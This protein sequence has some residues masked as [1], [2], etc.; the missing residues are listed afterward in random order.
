MVGVK[1]MSH[2]QDLERSVLFPDA[3]E[4]RIVLRRSSKLFHCFILVLQGEKKK[5]IVQSTYWLNE[6]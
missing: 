6:T 2:S 5:Q 1:G 3:T 4:S